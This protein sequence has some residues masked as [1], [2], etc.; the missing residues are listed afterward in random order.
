MNPF[1]LEEKTILVTGASSGIGRSIAIESSKMGAR[2]IV[3]G[4]NKKRL[5]ETFNSLNGDNHKLYVLDLNNSG[6]IKALVLQLPL[7]NGIVHAAGIS[8][9]L[10]LKFITK[11]SFTDILQTNLISASELT[12]YLYR[13]KKIKNQGSVV[14][15]SS[16]ASNHASLGSIMYMASKGGLNSFSKGVALEFAKLGIRSN[17]VQPGMVATNFIKI[18]DE[19]MKVDVKRYPL[20][21]YGTPNEI[22]YATIYLLSDASIWITGSSIVIDG[23]LSLS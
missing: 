6:E 20:G 1:S 17:V 2:V 15:I 23:G 11:E 19:E 18:T 14:F 12:K 3:L 22:A 8:K 7:L 16:I 5:T 9:R 10:P 21:R 13:K 4:R